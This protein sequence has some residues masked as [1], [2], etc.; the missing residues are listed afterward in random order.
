MGV[1]SIEGRLSGTG[2]SAMSQVETNTIIIPHFREVVH[3]P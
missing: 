3:R 1:A 2:T